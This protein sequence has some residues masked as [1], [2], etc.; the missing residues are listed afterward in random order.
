MLN[1]KSIKNMILDYIILIIILIFIL[2]TLCKVYLI[3]NMDLFKN[4][5]NNCDKIFDNLF[6]GN[7][8]CARNLDFIKKNNIKYI[9]N[10]SNGIPN[11]FEYNKDIKYFNLFVADSL[12]ENDINIMYKKLHEFVILLDKFIDF[13][14]GNILVHCYAGRQRSAILIAAYLVYKYKMTPD[15][16]YDYILDKRPEAFHY[17][18]SYN[19]HK[20]LIQYY[21]DLYYFE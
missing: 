21:N 10:I 14:D 2:L 11:Y 8:D 18:K 5:P 6:L 4:G 7:I 3:N 1:Y 17:G 9:F 19:F 12:L 15:E 13:N 16:A 20:S